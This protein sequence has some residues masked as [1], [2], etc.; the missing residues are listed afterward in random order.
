MGFQKW[1]KSEENQLAISPNRCENV[2]STKRFGELFTM[3]EWNYHF[4]NHGIIG[5][6][7]VKSH[8]CLHKINVYGDQ[9]N[10]GFYFLT[11]GWPRNIVVLLNSQLLFKWENKRNMSL[12]SV[13]T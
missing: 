4:E 2:N 13:F 10:G 5:K 12:I 7:M 3:K 11:T 1:K 8:C 6:E 9:S